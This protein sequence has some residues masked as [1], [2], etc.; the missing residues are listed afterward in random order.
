MWSGPGPARTWTGVPDLRSQRF[1]NLGQVPDLHLSYITP[2]VQLFF[3]STYS[4]L[5]VRNGES[6]G[7]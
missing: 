1:G 4:T 3:Q 2:E 6:K 5:G 7:L